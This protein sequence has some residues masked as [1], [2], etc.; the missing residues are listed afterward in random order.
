MY[1]KET[2]LLPGEQLIK[3]EWDNIEEWLKLEEMQ[4]R[5]LN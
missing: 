1:S 2:L 5:I 4:Q 3:K